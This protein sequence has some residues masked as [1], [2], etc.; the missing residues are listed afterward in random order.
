MIDVVDKKTLIESLREYKI[1]SIP[2]SCDESE[3]KGYNDGIDLAITVV[4]MTPSKEKTSPI[5]NKWIT[6]DYKYGK[7]R[8]ECDR[9]H[10]TTDTKYN[11]CPHCG[12]EMMK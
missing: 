12:T 3:I 10:Q 8:Y 2:C 11:Y 9:C 6:H 7:E 1:D 4:A 5:Q